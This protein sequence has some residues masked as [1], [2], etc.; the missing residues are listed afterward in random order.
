MIVA[1][2]FLPYADTLSKH[3]FKSQTVL[4]TNKFSIYEAAK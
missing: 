1:N 2:R 4:Q 3:Y